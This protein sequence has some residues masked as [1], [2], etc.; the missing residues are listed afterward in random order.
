MTGL[1]A[2]LA[3]GVYS[4]CWLALFFAY[5]IDRCGICPHVVVSTDLF[6]ST[7]CATM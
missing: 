1:S 5:W 2:A 3:A 4:A 7:A 6:A